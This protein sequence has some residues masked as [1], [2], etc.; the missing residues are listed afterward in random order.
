MDV[1]LIRAAT[2]QLSKEAAAVPIMQAGLGWAMQ[3]YVKGGG[4]FEGASS[5]MFNSED[6]WL[7]K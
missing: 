3:P 4:F 5:S 7:K 1:N 2:D 6:A